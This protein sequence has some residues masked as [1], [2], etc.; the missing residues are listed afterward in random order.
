MHQESEGQSRVP[1]GQI[2]TLAGQG[3]RNTS[4]ASCQCQTF[5][6][7]L[8]QTASRKGELRQ[9]GDHGGQAW[10]AEAEGRV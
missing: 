5:N 10:Q 8:A 1:A 3:R 9:E 2:K 7:D 6:N 4:C